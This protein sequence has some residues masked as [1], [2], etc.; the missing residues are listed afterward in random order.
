MKNKIIFF[1]WFF[2]FEL[3]LKIHRKLEWFEYKNDHNSRKKNRKINFFYDSAHSASFMYI[4]H[5]WKKKY[6]DVFFYFVKRKKKLKNCSCIHIMLLNITH[7]LGLNTQ[8]NH[9]W[10]EGGGDMRPHVVLYEIPRVHYS[11]NSDSF[12]KLVLIFL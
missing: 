7:I 3:S 1:L 12:I 6:F 8:F 2:F 10:R 4:W 9:F 5:F 11:F